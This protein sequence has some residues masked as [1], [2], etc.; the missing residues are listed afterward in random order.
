MHASR[1]VHFKPG[2]SKTSFAPSELALPDIVMCSQQLDGPTALDRI[3]PGLSSSFVVVE[4]QVGNRVKTIRMVKNS[5]EVKAPIEE[6]GIRQTKKKFALNSTSSTLGN[7]SEKWRTT[8][9]RKKMQERVEVVVEQ[10]PAPPPVQS[11]Q[12]EFEDL[13][14]EEGNNFG[15]VCDEAEL[16]Q[17]AEEFEEVLIW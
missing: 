17:I 2:E 3:R 10:P 1:E 8:V 5:V 15:Q 4:E 9:G 14:A 6:E 11:I 16:E 7:F 13:F 12:M